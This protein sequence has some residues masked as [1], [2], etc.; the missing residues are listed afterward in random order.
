[1][2][3]NTSTLR[4]T[5]VFWLNS[6]LLLIGLTTVSQAQ[7]ASDNNDV[8]METEES[9][10]TYK[11]QAAQISIFPFLSTNGSN[12]D[13]NNALSIN[14]LWG[15]NGGVNG[16][17]VGLLGNSIKRDV[18]G[19]QM[20]SL[21]NTVGGN[22]NG[23]QTSGLLNISRGNVNGFQSTG[24]FNIGGNIR[25]GQFSGIFNISK[26][27]NGGQFAGISN[28]ATHV[29]GIQGS[30]I[31]NLSTHVNGLQLAGISNSGKD[32]KG[33]QVS[34]LLNLA[35]EVKGTQIGFINIGKNVKGAQI[36]FINIVDSIEGAP[37]GFI[38]IVR[39]NGYNRLEV[40]GGETMYLTLGLKFGAKKFYNILQVGGH[41][42][43][44]SW[45]L[46]YG[47]GSV[48]P[49]SERWHANVELVGLHVNENK[50]WTQALNLTGQ[51]RF[52]INYQLAKHF[53]VFIGPTFNVHTSQLYNPD[54]GKYGSNLMP[55]SFFDETNG[56]TNVKMW[57]GVTGGVRF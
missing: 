53:N 51:F 41:I 35:K 13:K 56:S 30:G 32:V 18:N 37:I 12:L 20:A 29:N 4:K 40:A 8:L 14:L 39:K 24:I 6:I 7:V 10:T 55:Y 34:G 33:A 42:S 43:P 28:I 36:G 50:A 52:T 2:K 5:P 19:I 9:E 45:A 11:T 48:I 17:E 27:V 1:M 46:G 47:V 3:T 44:S 25:G 57:V 31:S 16:M 49:F 23:L 38:N 21:F 26:A 54:T 22:V 15:V